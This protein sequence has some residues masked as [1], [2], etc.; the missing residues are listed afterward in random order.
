M[1]LPEVS[2]K[3]KALPPCHLSR[4]HIH[5][6]DYVLGS[7]V[8]TDKGIGHKDNIKL[9]GK[10]SFYQTLKRLIPAPYY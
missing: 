6:V 10:V 3:F 4:V 8:I 7:V 5:A 2:A 9:E 1:F